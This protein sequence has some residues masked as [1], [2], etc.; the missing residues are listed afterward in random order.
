M[1]AL[2]CLT[3]C[4]LV[5]TSFNWDFALELAHH[6][7]VQTLQNPLVLGSSYVDLVIMARA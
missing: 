1:V 4:S 5:Y 2:T 7:Q 6:E 3:W